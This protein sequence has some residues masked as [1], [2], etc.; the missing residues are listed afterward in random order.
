MSDTALSEDNNEFINNLW[1]LHAEIAEVATGTELDPG[2]LMRL[3]ALGVNQ[4]LVALASLLDAP[5][6]AVEDP[7]Q[8]KFPFGEV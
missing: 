3:T 1:A 8:L 7:R 6:V 5:P 4:C 2:H